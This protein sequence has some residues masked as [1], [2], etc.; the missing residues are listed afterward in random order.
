MSFIEI[1]RINSSK[2][3]PL[4]QSEIIK[5]MGVAKSWFYSIKHGTG[6][7]TLAV[8]KNA[9]DALECYPSELL[10]E[11][12]QKPLNI[13]NTVI[14]EIVKYVQDIL[15]ASKEDEAD[16]EPEQVAAVI[17]IMLKTKYQKS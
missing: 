17:G 9:A 15:E 13:N 12:W 6:G 2:K 1:D 7:Q 5:R 10:P 16:Y 4:A 14:K 8:L 11:D 3:K